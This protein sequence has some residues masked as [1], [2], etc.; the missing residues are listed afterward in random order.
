MGGKKL[1][2]CLIVVFL[3][4]SSTVVAQEFSTLDISPPEIPVSGSQ[5]Q[6]FELGLF[7]KTKTMENTSNIH[8]NMDIQ[9]DNYSRKNL[10][11]VRENFLKIFVPSGDFKIILRGDSLETPGGDYYYSSR[12]SIDK[13]TEKTII[14]WPVG[15]VRGTVFLDDSVVEN[16]NLKFVCG[17]QYGSL[18]E[19]TT[20]QFGSFSNDY[21]PIGECKIYARHGQKVGFVDVDVAE[22]QIQNIEIRL[23]KSA[24]SNSVLPIVLLLIFFAAI[25]FLLFWK[26]RKPK[27]RPKKNKRAEDL[28]KTFNEKE[29]KI[30][31]ILLDKKELYQN[32]VVHETGIPKTSLT[33]ILLG[34]EQKKVVEIAKIGKTKK[35]KLTKWFLNQ[36]KI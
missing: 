12:W 22:G 32:R 7:F 27:N 5:N 2:N 1:V 26:A 29:K 30:V 36:E 16:A 17:K 9:S 19:Q 28:L 34:L 21:L 35:I 31:E 4:F 25:V 15:S 3:I 24:G 13:D 6:N 11:F 14:F 8:L 18:E 20:D 23:D 33:R 10:Y